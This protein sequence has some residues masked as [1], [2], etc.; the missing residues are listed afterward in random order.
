MQFTQR[1]RA[2]IKRGEITTSVRIW[3]SPRVKEGRYYRLEEGF[4]YIEQIRQIEFDAITPR[5]ARD[6]GFAG[7]ADLLKTAKHGAGENVY[8]IKFRYERRKPSS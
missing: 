1:L 6:S 4:V 3:K 7:I 5:M 8:L 2:P